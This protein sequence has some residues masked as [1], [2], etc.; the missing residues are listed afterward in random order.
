MI[1]KRLAL[2]WILDI[3]PIDKWLVIHVCCEGMVFEKISA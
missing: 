3:T 1:R 2:V